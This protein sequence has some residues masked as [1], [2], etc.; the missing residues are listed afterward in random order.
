M[1][2]KKITKARF[3][4]DMYCAYLNHDG[5]G[6]TCDCDAGTTSYFAIHDNDK[7]EKITEEEFNKRA[8]VNN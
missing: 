3:D 2:Y 7:E 6:A 8:R 4:H 1:K 5:D